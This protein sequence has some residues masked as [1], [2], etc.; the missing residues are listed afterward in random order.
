[1]VVLA[2]VC[3]EVGQRE[4]GVSVSFFTTK[5][6]GEAEKKKEKKRRENCLGVY[7]SGQTVCPQLVRRCEMKGGDSKSKSMCSRRVVRRC[8]AI[9]R[10]EAG[11][12]GYM[13]TWSFLFD[14][15][16][17]FRGGHVQCE[18]SRCAHYASEATEWTR[19]RTEDQR[20]NV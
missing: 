20:T 14:N 6:G 5:R 8:V 1:M 19:S 15:K 11:G 3:H 13:G 9:K 17:R 12:L 10:N 16:G 2:A 4:D 7:T 18:R